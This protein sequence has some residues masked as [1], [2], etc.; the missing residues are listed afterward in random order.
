MAPG[1][2][3]LP[4]DP[5]RNA[6]RDLRVTAADG[7]Q[8]HARDYGSR[9]AP[10]LAVI[11]LP[12]LTRNAKDF[13]DIALRLSGDPERPRR[14][15]AV[16]Y[17]GRGLS[18]H[19]P[20][21]RN[22]EVTTEARDC[23]DVATAAGIHEAVVIGTSRGGLLAMMIAALRPGL[24]RAVVLNDVGPE[25]APQG[26]A[27]I[28]AAMGRLPPRIA[29]WDE[30]T[31]LTRAALAAS[32]PKLT[33][34]EWRQLAAHGFREENGGLRPDFDLNLL[35]PLETLNLETEL[36]A[37]WPQFDGL[38]RLPTLAIRGALSDI[39]SAE[40]LERMRARHPRL[41]AVTLPDVGHAPRLS[42]P[43][44]VEAIEG[45]IREAEDEPRE[46]SPARAEPGRVSDIRTGVD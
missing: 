14:V 42:E 41:R 26:L 18:A 23:L 33:D 36:P 12:G 28:R 10:G 13:H 16:D 46:A 39:L 43:G 44:A 29:S 7:L 24:L 30:A 45:L 4:G 21:W 22:Y 40:T 32:F 6:W 11:C 38:R 35:K 9:L 8:L 31:A 25:I 17:R 27:R 1:A 3:T 37:L 5:T 19:D 20:D 2:P 34:A 15:L